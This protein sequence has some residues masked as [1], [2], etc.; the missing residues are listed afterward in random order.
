MELGMVGEEQNDAGDAGHGR[1][2]EAEVGMA[3]LE[4]SDLGG[5]RRQGPEEGGERRDV[6]RKRT[7]RIHSSGFIGL[8]SKLCGE[9]TPIKV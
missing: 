6:S 4:P 1:P 3:G 9:K 5:G 2:G 8:Q 7:V